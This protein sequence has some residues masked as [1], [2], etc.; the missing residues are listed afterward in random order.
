ME[1]M[2]P[3]LRLIQSVRYAMESGESV[4]S[5]LRMYLQLP[6]DSLGESVRTWLQLFERGC[7]T[8]A[9]LSTISNPTRRHLLML[10]EKGLRGEPILASLTA[11]SDEVQEESWAEMELFLA[12]LPFRLLLPLVFFIFP[13]FLL[14]LLGPLLLRVVAGLG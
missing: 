13:A 2:T 7:G 4:R 9:Y 12:K 10:L 14:L 3:S 11:F 1:N 6:V 5:G 8:E